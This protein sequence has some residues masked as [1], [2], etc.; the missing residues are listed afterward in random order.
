MGEAFATRHQVLRTPISLIKKREQELLGYIVYKAAVHPHLALF[1]RKACVQD[2][3]ANQ[4][5]RPIAAIH[6]N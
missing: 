6:T 5:S 2:Y 3:D 4:Y 1:C